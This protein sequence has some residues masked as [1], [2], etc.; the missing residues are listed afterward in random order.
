MATA[1][2]NINK[3]VEYSFRMKQPSTVSKKTVYEMRKTLSQLKFVVKTTYSSTR[4][5]S[6][7]TFSKTFR[8]KKEALNVIREV[9]DKAGHVNMVSPDQILMAEFQI[10]GPWN[11]KLSAKIFGIVKVVCEILPS[12]SCWIALTM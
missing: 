5:I 10:K 1:L 8:N 6:G 3:A 2:K 11:D 4:S 12:V 9:E 7:V